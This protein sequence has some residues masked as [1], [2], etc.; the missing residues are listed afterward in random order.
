MTMLGSRWNRRHPSPP[1]SLDGTLLLRNRVAWRYFGHG[2]GATPSPAEFGGVGA[3]GIH[4][5]AV[6][7]WLLRN[8]LVGVR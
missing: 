8:R 5:Y 7:S 1:N 6:E 4:G 2:G 3:P